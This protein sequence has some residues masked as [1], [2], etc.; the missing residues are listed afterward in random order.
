MRG[1]ANTILASCRA[2]LTAVSDTQFSARKALLDECV[3]MAEHGM[4]CG[5]QALAANVWDTLI[6]G[7]AFATPDWLKPNGQWG[8][9]K[10]RQ[11]I[12]AVED[13]DPTMLQFRQAS[14]YGA[15]DHTSGLYLDAETGRIC[16]WDRYGDRTPRYG[17]LTTCLEEMADRLEAPSLTGGEK[18]GLLDLR[19]LV[20]GPPPDLNW[21]ALWKP[22]PENW[23]SVPGGSR[24]GRRQLQVRA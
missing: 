3:H 10:F 22:F 13:D 2:T 14:S 19:A 11:S 15:N 9:R 12:P 6:R 21:A 4:S 8:Y 17:S 20:W 24:P 7:L 5:A 18:P 1:P 16:R 23:R